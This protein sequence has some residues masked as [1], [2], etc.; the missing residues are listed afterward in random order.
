MRDFADVDAADVMLPNADATGRL[1]AA[2][3]QRCPPGIVLLLRGPLGAGKTT[4]V[5]GFAQALSAGPA[6]SPTFVLAHSYPRGRVPLW[7]LDFFRL[8]PEDVD[9]LD[10]TQYVTPTSIA[11]VEWPERARVTW[12]PDRIE[13]DFAVA[14]EGRRA[15]LRGFGSARR[16]VAA[17]A[18]RG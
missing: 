15:R 17:V 11:L 7:H 5:S 10:L 13:I 14:G 9:A 4:F 3:A 18:E 12:P 6:A 1:A 2:L 16:T 8:D